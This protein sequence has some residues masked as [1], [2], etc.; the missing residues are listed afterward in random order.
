LAA[1]LLLNEDQNRAA[2]FNNRYD[3]L[4]RKRPALI[5]KIKDVYGVVPSEEETAPAEPTTDD[6][7]VYDTPGTIDGGEF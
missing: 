1:Q 4:K 3:E 2:Y 7:F 6:E 5:T